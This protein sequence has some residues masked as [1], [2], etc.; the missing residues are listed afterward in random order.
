MEREVRRGASGYRLPIRRSNTPSRTRS[1]GSA[2][3]SWTRLPNFDAFLGLLNGG[4]IIRRLASLHW[5]R[6]GTVGP[7]PGYYQDAMTSCRP[8]RRASFPSFGGTSVAL[9]TVRS[10]VAECTA[11]AAER[12][13]YESHGVYGY[14]K[15][16]D[17][18]QDQ[19]IVCCLETVRSVLREKRLF[20]GTKR[21]FVVTTDS[22][23]SMPVA[24][25]HLDR[26][27]EATAPDQKWA[28]D[29][30]YHYSA[31]FRFLLRR[32]GSACLRR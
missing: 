29:I 23:H 26:N 3:V 27:F 15:V 19:E 6:P 10:S 8:S 18:L 2:A 20:S 16:H 17:D 13:H 22:N 30:T 32:R 24:E 4:S 12:A 28:A 21:K 25:N 14:R 31:F 9:A 7:L 5:F 1:L 11:E